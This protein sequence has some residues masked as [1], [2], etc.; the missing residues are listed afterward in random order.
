[1]NEVGVEKLGVGLE[2]IDP[3]TD[4][5]ISTEDVCYYCYCNNIIYLY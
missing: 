4:G 5:P 2:T 1:M 3:N